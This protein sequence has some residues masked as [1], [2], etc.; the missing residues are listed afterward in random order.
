MWSLHREV[1]SNTTTAKHTVAIRGPLFS[2]V[3]DK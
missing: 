1:Q 2:C 3:S